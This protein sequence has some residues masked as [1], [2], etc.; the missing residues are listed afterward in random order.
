[1]IG[2]WILIIRLAVSPISIYFAFPGQLGGKYICPID[3]VNK[4]LKYT[5]SVYHS[6]LFLIGMA[7]LHSMKPSSRNGYNKAW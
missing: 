7:G 3:F 2:I 5:S 6:F 1:M 4:N